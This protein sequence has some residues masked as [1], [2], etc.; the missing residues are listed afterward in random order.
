[1]VILLV[2]QYTPLAI[3]PM[4]YI[5]IHFISFKQSSGR[6][7]GEREALDR[8]VPLHFFIFYLKS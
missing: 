7:G 6:G 5:H 3:S 1:M 2:L 8:K 4:L